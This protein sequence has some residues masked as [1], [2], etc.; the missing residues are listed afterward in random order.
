LQERADW[1]LAAEFYPIIVVCAM[2]GF[3]GDLSASSYLLA[4]LIANNCAS[5]SWHLISIFKQAQQLA[6]AKTLIYII[7]S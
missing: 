7:Y 3:L 1:H 2:F 4:D 5:L 6:L